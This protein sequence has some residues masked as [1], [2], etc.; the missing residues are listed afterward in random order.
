MRLASELPL[1]D[2]LLLYGASFTFLPSS[3]CLCE[4]HTH[5]GF[6]SVSVMTEL[7]HHLRMIDK[8]AKSYR[9]L[10]VFCSITII[11]LVLNSNQ[12]LVLFCFKYLCSCK[13][14]LFTFLLLLSSGL[15]P[16]VH[17]GRW[18]NDFFLPGGTNL[19]LTWVHNI[20]N[21]KSH[22]Y[23]ADWLDAIQNTNSCSSLN[24]ENTQ[25]LMIYQHVNTEECWSQRCTR[26][27]AHSPPLLHSW[28]I[29]SSSLRRQ[30]VS[31]QKTP[32]KHL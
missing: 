20:H 13:H 12:D 23:V 1:Y 27:H 5:Q 31:A 19:A 18:M 10:S 15:E 26:Q 14:G 11:A 28:Q 16:L 4:Q 8:I 24:S 29:W 21:R 7:H 6:Q 9:V 17:P 3:T 2:T 32:L 22:R 30:L 25:L